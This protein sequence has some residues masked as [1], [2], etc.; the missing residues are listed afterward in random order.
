M[1]DFL[2]LLDAALLNSILR[3]ATPILLAALGGLL[4]DRVGLFNIA[5]E[6]KMLVGA[7]AAVV[8]DYY[9]G[10][11]FGG[12]I[13]ACLAAAMVSALYGFLTIHL[14]G[15]VIVIGIAT[16]LLT[17]GLTV[18]LLRALF[19]VKGAFQDPRLTPL[20]KLPLP[21]LAAIP[22]LGP[23]LSNHTW[24][25]Y[26][27]LV[28]VVL[29]QVILFHTPLGLRMR[30]VGEQ[31]DAAGTLGVSVV[32]LRYLAVLT[33]GLLCGL[34]GAQLSLGN[35]TLFVENMSAGRGWIAVVSVM[36]GQSTPMGVFLA[37]SLFGFADSLG[38][39][40]QGLGLASQFTGMVPYLVT[41]LALFFLRARQKR[42][43]S[44]LAM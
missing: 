28:L 38:F 37:S 32:R 15:D 19:D 23:L 2:H 24:I 17:S 11:A 1:S 44:A 20:E 21:G 33:C 10:S 16:N 42:R 5:L 31:P 41:L 39:R 13:M 7:F 26:L 3:F 18:F 25:V 35:V 40:L 4:C 9:L 12:M 34:A 6:G 22:V 27:T 29:L 30:G 43:R 8:G 14:K 36:L